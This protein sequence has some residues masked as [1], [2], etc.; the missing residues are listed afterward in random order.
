MSGFKAL[1]LGGLG[2]KKRQRAGAG[3]RAAADADRSAIERLLKASSL[4]L[5]GTEEN[6]G[7]F[8]V[9]EGDDGT[10]IGA[11]GLE[12]Y[13]RAGLLRS[14]VVAGSARRRGIAAA[15]ID[16]VVARARTEGCKALYLLTLDAEG[17]FKRFGFEVI[18]RDKAP[19]SIRGS[20][21]FASLCPASAVLMRKRLSA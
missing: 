1:S 18:A 3:P 6:L 7:L 17:F 8:F 12:L 16:Q 21:E 14:V 20:P 2:E 4:P 11:A 15:L 19:A 13:G 10:V 5:T 9:H